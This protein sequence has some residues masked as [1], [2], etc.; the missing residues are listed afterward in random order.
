[1]GPPSPRPSTQRATGF[2][3][4]RAVW[5]EEPAV[6]PPA[7]EP[8]SPA[9]ASGPPGHSHAGAHQ[10]GALPSW[11]PGLRLL[12]WTNRCSSTSCSHC[13]ALS[14]F[15]VTFKRAFVHWREMEV[16]TQSTQD[17]G[18]Q[19]I[20]APGRCQ[21]QKSSRE[22]TGSKAQEAQPQWA[23][24]GDACLPAH[25]PRSQKRVRLPPP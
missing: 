5:N 10:V 3:L 13:R 14:S 7:Y 18:C 21:G 1:M 11:G 9:P 24:G 15:S 17:S 19:V 8:R 25:G 22:R 2:C 20:E 23:V 4:W 6:G 12:T 16:G